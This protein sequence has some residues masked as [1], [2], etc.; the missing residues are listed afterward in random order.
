VVTVISQSEELS[1]AATFPPTDLDAWRRLALAAL[2]K[3]GAASEETP[4]DR[5]DDL[6]STTS[7]EGIRVAPLYTAASAVPDTGAPGVAPFT[8]GRRP[9]GAVSSGW[10]VRQRHCHPDVAE[11]RTAVREDVSNGVTS[12]WLTR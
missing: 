8:R 1:L 3:S 10:D 2:Q 5:V 7:F 9:L 12:L 11:T 6:L 4:A